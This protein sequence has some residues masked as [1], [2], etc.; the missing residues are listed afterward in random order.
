MNYPPRN[1][2]TPGIVC[3]ITGTADP[4]CIAPLQAEVTLSSFVAGKE[5]NSE[6]LN[7]PT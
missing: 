3:A 2:E 4:L 1:P 6:V 7:P 5:E